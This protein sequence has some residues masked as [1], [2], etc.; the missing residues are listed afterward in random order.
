MP[1]SIIWYMAWCENQQVKAK[2]L[3]GDGNDTSLQLSW[4]DLLVQPTSLPLLRPQTTIWRNFHFILPLIRTSQ[5]DDKMNMN[6]YVD[7]NFSATIQI[8]VPIHV[9]L[10]SLLKSSFNAP[11]HNPIISSLSVLTW[12]RHTRKASR[13]TA[14]TACTTGTAIL[15]QSNSL[16]ASHQLGPTNQLLRRVGWIQTFF[17]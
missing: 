3:Y 2:Q 9:N 14:L 1:W 10:E 5:D 11:M 16:S 17:A 13:W 7:V 4:G 15:T 6:T 8:S 12:L